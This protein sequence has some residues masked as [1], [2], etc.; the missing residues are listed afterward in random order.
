MRLKNW[1]LIALLA[2]PLA[3]TG[4]AYGQSVV[5]SDA[6]SAD[7]GYLCPLTGDELPCPDCCPINSDT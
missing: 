1:K 4:L 7:A 5:G 6:S 2:I 3:L